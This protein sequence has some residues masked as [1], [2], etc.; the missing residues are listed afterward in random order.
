MNNRVTTK[1]IAKMANVS[2]GTV[3]RVIHNRGK[4]SETAKLRVEEVL[5][6]I[7]YKPNAIAQALRANKKLN[8]AVLIPS[9]ENDPY[10]AASLVGIEQ[11]QDKF[12]HFKIEVQK[13][14]F[15]QDNPSNF[16]KVASDVL[17]SKP[18]GILVVPFFYKESI[19]FFGKCKERDIPYVTFNTHL[20]DSQ[21]LCFIGQNLRQSGRVAANLIHL[22]K[23]SEGPILI[24]HIDEDISNAIH[25]QEKEQG[26]R[27][28]FE[29]SKQVISTVILDS[30]PL[31][32]EKLIS[33]VKDKGV[34]GVFVTT[35]KAY[36][37]AEKLKQ[38]ISQCVV[39]G[40]DLLEENIDYLKSS[41]IDFLINQ[42]PQIQSNYGI[43]YLIDNLLFKKQVP[44]NKFLPISIVS[45]ENLESYNE[46]I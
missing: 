3:D 30:N 1:D 40:Y 5:K 20:D 27:G 11:E 2:R 35:S 17:D 25:M 46:Y 7:N 26:F 37:I 8:L 23:K 36:T 9:P 29:N 18:D 32:V 12:Y 45:K 15:D 22:T 42:N 16:N 41:T 13:F 10:W 28:Y 43:N 31:E 4:V 38:D 14:Y 21:S 39:I 6:E 34:V 44:K 33:D 19:E 24:I